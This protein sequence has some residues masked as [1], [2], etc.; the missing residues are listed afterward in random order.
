MPIVTIQF[1][2]AEPVTQAQKDAL[3]AKS[4]DMI[5]E[6]LHKDPEITWVILQEIPTTDWGVGGLNAT[7]RF[8]KE[9]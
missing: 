4:T 6:V 7:A 1:T 2:G 5:T 8:P 9:D 3:I